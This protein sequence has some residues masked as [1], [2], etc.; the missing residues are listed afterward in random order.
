MR[1]A[2]SRDNSVTSQ[3]LLTVLI[4]SLAGVFSCHSAAQ[5][6]GGADGPRMLEEVVVT[7]SRRE[8][9]LSD[10]PAAITALTG[11]TL[12]KM[13]INDFFEISRSIP[14]LSSESLGPGRRKYTIRGISAT[15]GEPTVGFYLGE[16]PLIANIGTIR[17]VSAD[18][19]FTDLNRIEVLRGPQGTLY[20]SSSMGGTIRLI[21]NEP[22]TESF[23]GTLNTSVSSTD[24]GGGTN[25]QGD[26]TL[27]IPLLPD[28]A[29]VRLNAWHHN[30]EGFIDREF[31]ASVQS[32]LPFPE[33]GSIQG[34]RVNDEETSGF[35]A[36][37]KWT[38]SDN[39][40]LLPSVMH[41]KT[42]TGG[43][44]DITLG[45][46]N[47]SED[48]VQRF[49]EFSPEPFEDEWT[50]Y[51][52]EASWRVGNVSFLSSSSYFD[53][54]FTASEEGSEVLLFFGVSDAAA[55]G[56]TAVLT[57]D[58][59]TENFTQELR[60]SLIDPV[61]GFNVLAGLFYT[62]TDFLRNVD[63]APEAFGNL[64]TT[65]NDVPNKQTAVFGE[66]SYE[67]MP[68]L[69]LT[70]GARW[71]DYDL[72][73]NNTTSGLFNGGESTSTTE[74]DESD[75]NMK[76]NVSWDVAED[77]LIYAEVAE[78]F[79]PGSGTAPFPPTCNQE[80]QD[81]GL[82]PPPT[83]VDSDSVINYELGAKTSWMENRLSANV[84]A[85]Y[86]KWDDIQQTVFLDCGFRFTD[87]A[88]EATS[89]GFELEVDAVLTEQLSLQL[90]A[91][92]VD[93]QLEKDAVSLGA[94]A[95]D[96][97]TNVPEWGFSGL[98]DY[99]QK[100]ASDAA[101]VANLGVQYTGDSFVNYDFDDP[102]SKKGSYTLVNATVGYEWR[103]YR[104]SLFAK[105]LMDEQARLAIAESLVLN[106]EGRPRF[107]VNW[108]R[109]VGLKFN[110]K[111]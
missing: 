7:A 110:M 43:F 50:L 34:K 58:V 1:T 107:N 56:N 31:G 16:T 8:E 63:W 20:G 90:A 35:R 70:V 52:L 38:P 67:V 96:R 26:V 93:A 88:G 92:Y 61:Y 11:E 57:E 108:P 40:S 103:N 48:M 82:F 27:N 53:R 44:Q 99:R 19:K 73:T 12:E 37:L 86:I 18:P 29:A 109:T 23:S 21:P 15:G 9:G 30:N 33:S 14:G 91:S 59:E 98:L 45:S 104:L 97:L 51:S 36:A 6:G 2:K 66:L 75:I 46:V 76:F 102:F 54:E 84:A 47:P 106:V 111:F 3:Q 10:V 85:F 28:L 39:F 41:Q 13:N 25:Y 5:I 77:K 68:D 4:G 81:K 87:N 22:D 42:E 74:A 95:G 100:L 55:T 105:N 60:F 80:L 83:Q 89:R 65:V 79:R 17:Q 72:E 62:D 24:S 49:P 101:V 94:E 78:G 71:F 32:A 69:E 64:F